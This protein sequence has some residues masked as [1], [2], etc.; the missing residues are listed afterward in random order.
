M[1]R[2]PRRYRVLITSCLAIMLAVMACGSVSLA[3]ETSAPTATT[4]AS[5]TDTQAHALGSVPSTATTENRDSWLQ[6]VWTNTGDETDILL[7]T[8]QS[9]GGR[10]SEGEGTVI[11]AS[12]NNMSESSLDVNLIIQLGTGLGMSS[13]TGCS[14]NP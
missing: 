5:S 10:L 11:T 9:T 1:V 13:Q 3:T 8:L 12:A 4:P 14:G 7:V 6:P 2:S